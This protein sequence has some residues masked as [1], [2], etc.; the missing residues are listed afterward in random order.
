MIL[1]LYPNFIEIKS[2]NF[3]DTLSF[4]RGKISG[5]ILNKD[6]SKKPIYLLINY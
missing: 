1:I 4:G 6:L 2:L 3:V 5:G